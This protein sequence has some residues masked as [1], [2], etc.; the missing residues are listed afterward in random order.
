MHYWT[1]NTRVPRASRL[2][3]LWNQTAK[4]SA[5]SQVCFCTALCA[6]TECSSGNPAKDINPP[7]TDDCECLREN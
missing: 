5:S 7:Q 2:N 3:R 6:N 1:I 4:R